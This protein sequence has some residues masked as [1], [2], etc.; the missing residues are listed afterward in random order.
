VLTNNQR[1]EPTATTQAK[2][3]A[4]RALL[5]LHGMACTRHAWIAV[6]AS[7]CHVQHWARACV[8]RRNC[9]SGKVAARASSSPH[10]PVSPVQKRRLGPRIV[11]NHAGQLPSVCCSFSSLHQHAPGTPRKSSRGWN[12]RV[13]HQ[14]MYMGGGPLLSAQLSAACLR[15]ALQ[16]LVIECQ[17]G[18]HQLGPPAGQHRPRDGGAQQNSNRPREGSRTAGR[19][20]HDR[21]PPV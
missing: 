3:T 18:P 15:S 19:T 12:L 5:H 1:T 7:S 21:E 4:Y 6:H 8:N 17:G 10:L 16:S 11:L 9:P 14:V 13:T 20:L 2:Q